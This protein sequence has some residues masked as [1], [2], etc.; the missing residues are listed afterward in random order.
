MIPLILNY[1]RERFGVKMNQQTQTDK[2]KRLVTLKNFANPQNPMSDQDRVSPYNM[3]I[4][5]SREVVRI[6]QNIK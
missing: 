5:F 6:Y 4:I 1:Y 2:R 3:Y